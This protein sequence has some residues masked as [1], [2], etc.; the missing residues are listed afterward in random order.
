M[1]GACWRWWGLWLLL[2][3]CCEGF[4]AMVFFPVFGYGLG[5]ACGIVWRFGWVWVW[6]KETD[7]VPFEVDPVFF[8][9]LHGRILPR[10]GDLFRSGGLCAKGMENNGIHAHDGKNGYKCIDRYPSIRHLFPF[11][12]P[13]SSLHGTL[14]PPRLTPAPA[15]SPCR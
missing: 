2:L 10:N 4:V 12:S 1:V 9:C 8:G 7:G 13:S 15:F 5:L 6:E 11:S 3:F 14:S